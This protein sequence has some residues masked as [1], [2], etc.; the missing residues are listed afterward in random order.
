MN[1]PNC[2]HKVQSAQPVKATPDQI[3]SRDTFINKV[4]TTCGW[5]PKHTKSYKVQKSDNLMAAVYLDLFSPNG[6]TRLAAITLYWNET[7]KVWKV[8]AFNKY[9]MNPYPAE[10]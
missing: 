4:L 8:E 3:K 6:K 10:L 1:C 7:K 5:D 9:S 2:N